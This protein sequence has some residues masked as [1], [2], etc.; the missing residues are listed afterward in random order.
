MARFR[1]QP[2]QA[3]LAPVP[4]ARP[5]AATE[6]AALIRQ[7]SRPRAADAILTSLAR[8]WFEALPMRPRPEQFCARYPRVANRLALCWPEV[9]LTE[10]LFDDLLVDRRGGRRGF[11]APVLDE[12]RRLRTVHAARR[13]V[14]RSEALLEA[15]EPG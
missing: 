3:P 2:P 8:A 14:A 12:L 5:A 15:R 9:E 10:Q 4:A 1:F 7:R 13:D 11:P 6:A